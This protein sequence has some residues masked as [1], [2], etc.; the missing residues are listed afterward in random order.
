M[1]KT[2]FSEQ[3]D[4]LLFTGAIEGETILTLYHLLKSYEQG[5]IRAEEMQYEID[6][7]SPEFY[8]EVLRDE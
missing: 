7:L 2:K 5:M 8:L 3:I 6:S 1:E 4:D